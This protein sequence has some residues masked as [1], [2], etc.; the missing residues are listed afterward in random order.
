MGFQSA[1][2]NLSTRLQY[3]IV[4][5]LS[6]LVNLNS[7]FNN[8]ALDDVVV[9]TENNI[10]KKGISGIPELLSSDYFK[11]YNLTGAELSGARYRPVSLIVFALEYQFFGTIPFISHLINILLFSILVLLIFNLLRVELF[12]RETL[13]PFVAVLLFAVHPIHAEVI[14]NVKGRDEILTFIF[15]IVSIT[16]FL[17]YKATKK[18]YFLVLSCFMFFLGLLTKETAITYIA[19]F[20]LLLY[21]FKG[22]SIISTLK[23]IWPIVTTLALYFVI[24]YHFVGFS[25]MEIPDVT[26]SP[27]ILAS[28]LQAFATKIFVVSKYFYLLVFPITLTSEYGYNQIP[29]LNV[30]S[31]EFVV[32]ITV[33]ISLVLISLFLFKERSVISFGILYVLITLSVGT[34]LI[35]DFGAP[36][37]ERMLFIPSLGFCILLSYILFLVLKKS[38]KILV[39][40]LFI[41]PFYSFSTVKRNSEWKDN[42]SLFFADI[43]K[44]PNSSRL[45]LFVSE[46][47]IG[48]YLKEVSVENKSIYL[49]SAKY[50]I[51][52]SMQ[53]LPDYSF[54]YLRLGLIYFY[55]GDYNSAADSWLHARKL[56]PQN[57][58]GL[59]W[60]KQLSEW[61]IEE[62]KGQ[63]AN[64]N[65][66]LARECFLTANRLD[67]MNEIAIQKLNI[68]K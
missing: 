56:D 15:L 41:I 53:I 35:F 24:R 7:I 31:L 42:D 54:A 47:Y 17:K 30:N 8:Y 52:R 64:S 38:R 16:T 46:I 36:M 28:P 18:K 37:A 49:D 57:P 43:V 23:S 12:N 21:F 20:P 3:L 40:L 26:N 6:I 58:D 67:P 33:L 25:Q 62:G 27:Y 39:C 5:A 32:A 61:Y 10:V 22:E 1:D 66:D 48:K 34:N 4:F 50:Y 63:L 44:S 13:I 65:V 2:F 11:G 68:L 29:Y 9:L 14:A 51:D 59:K 60:T 19:V 55:K 45:N